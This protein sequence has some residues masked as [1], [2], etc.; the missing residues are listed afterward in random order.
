MSCDGFLHAG[1]R[2]WKSSDHRL[3]WRAG[4]VSQKKKK[5]KETKYKTDREINEICHQRMDEGFLQFPSF[6]AESQ[7]LEIHKQDVLKF[8]K[9]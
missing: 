4:T 3:H 2:I 6:H 9:Y 8:S 1:Q 5:K 7:V